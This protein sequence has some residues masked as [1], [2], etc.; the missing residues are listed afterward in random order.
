METAPEDAG[1]SPSLFLLSARA[2]TANMELL[3]EDVWGLPTVILQGLLPLMNIY[4]LER[5]E[6]TAVRKGLSTQSTWCKLWNDIM[7]SKPSRFGTV[8]CWRKKFLEAFFHNVLRGILDVSSDRRLI[9]HRFSPLMHSSR[10]VSELTICNKQQGVTELPPTVLEC[11]AQSVET[12]KFLHL[13]SSDPGTQK[14]LRLLLH[15]LIHHGRVTKVSVLSWPCPD[16]QLLVLILTISAGYWELDPDSSCSLCRQ[17][18]HD[19]EPG[20]DPRSCV[21]PGS[22]EDSSGLSALLSLQPLNISQNVGSPSEQS[23]VPPE[24][25]SAGSPLSRKGTAHHRPPDRTSSSTSQAG[26]DPASKGPA[27]GHTSDHNDLYDFIFNVSTTLGEGNTPE[28]PPEKKVGVGASPLLG[29]IHYRSVRTLNLHNVPLTLSSC[30][31]LCHLLCSWTAL[32]RLTMAYNDL[33]ANIQLVLESL[34]ALSRDPRCCLRVFSLSDFTTFVPMLE[35]AHT[36]LRIFPQLQLLSLSYDLES[37]K[38][39]LQTLELRF[40]QDPVQVERLVSVLMASRSL[41]ELSLDNAMFP[42][43]DDLRRVLRVIADCNTSLR[44]LSFHDMKMSD[45]HCEILHLLNH[46]RLEEMKF[47]FCRLFE[48]GS[49]DF[50]VDFVAA[51]KRNPN[52]RILKLSGNRLGNEGLFVLG[53]LFSSD[54]VCGIHYLD[55]SSNCIKPDGLL[56]FAQKLEGC[57]EMK[58]QQLSVSQN[59]L[60]RDPVLTQEALQ[61]LAGVCTVVSDSWDSGQAFADHISV[62]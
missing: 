6:Q 40:P 45:V 34:S 25:Q 43:Q 51:I 22:T 48:E 56:R 54:S 26:L 7:K 44:R 31:S 29:D 49:G 47:S 24:N 60:D 62:M 55:V 27:R 12:L 53:D 4:Y 14:S 15:H 57:G 52:V 13:R 58:L 11:L 1:G 46:S 36:I 35:L 18:T 50:L 2:V 42:G 61:A 8:T 16:N 33:G 28:T 17:T 20:G 9:D 5:I 30:R 19:T 23:T 10:H 21:P 38:N 37:P 41:L 39:R 59:L 3:E 32:E